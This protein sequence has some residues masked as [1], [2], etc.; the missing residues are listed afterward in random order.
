LPLKKH[1][2]SS[3]RKER[4]KERKTET[5]ELLEMP[6]RGSILHQILSRAEEIKFQSAAEISCGDKNTNLG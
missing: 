4:K 5:L 6:P 1:T 3:V 2:H